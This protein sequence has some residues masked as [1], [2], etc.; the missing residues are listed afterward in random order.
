MKKINEIVCVTFDEADEGKAFTDIDNSS[1]RPFCVDDYTVDRA[2]KRFKLISSLCS[3]ALPSLPTDCRIDNTYSGILA[4][5]LF[6]LNTLL[7]SMIESR[8]VAFLNSHRH[9]CAN[10]STKKKSSTTKTASTLCRMRQT[11]RL[12]YR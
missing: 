11:M 5:D 4:T 7:G 8:V 3:V 10:S 1:M 6:S 9:L 12:R 2:D